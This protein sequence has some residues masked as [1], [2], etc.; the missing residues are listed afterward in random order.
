MSDIFSLVKESSIPVNVFADTYSRERYVES[1][2]DLLTRTN[3]VINE[4]VKMLY[5]KILEADSVE[6]ENIAMKDFIQE[7]QAELDKLSFGIKTSSQRFAIAL[8]NYCSSVKDQIDAIG[9]KDLSKCCYRGEYI[10][11]DKARMLNSDA[12]QM[13]PYK[14]FER[15]FNFIGQLMQ[16]LPV[17]A[18]NKDKLEI[19][20]T[21]YKNFKKSMDNNIVEKTYQDL[22]GLNSTDVK[23]TGSAQSIGRLVCG[24]FKSSAEDDHNI[25][26]DEYTDAVECISSCDEFIDCIDQ[27]STHLINDLKHIISDLNDILM[28]DSKN[29]FK[30]DTTEDGIRNTSYSID[31]YTSNKIMWLIQEKVKQITVVFNKYILALSVKMECILGYMRQSADIINSFTYM[32]CKAPKIDSEDKT[33]TEE[34][35]MSDDKDNTEES[36]SD[37]DLDD[38]INKDE[39]VSEEEEQESKEDNALDGGDDILTKEDETE[40]DVESTEDEDD[41]EIEEVSGDE[42]PEVDF[43]PEANEGDS[44]K[45]AVLDVITS[46]HEYNMICDQISLFEYAATLLMEEETNSDDKKEAL[47]GA[48]E[49]I[50]KAAEQKQSVWQS[51]MSK[52]LKM[53]ESFKEALA[54]T[55][56][57][58]I[59]KLKEAGIEKYVKEKPVDVEIKMPTIKLSALD[60]IKIED[61]NYDTMKEFLNSKDEFIKKYYNEFMP[62]KD[63]DTLSKTIEDAVIDRENLITKGSGLQI[64]EY[65][66]FVSKYPSYTNELKSMTKVLED[67]QRKAAAIAKDMTKYKPSNESFTLEDFYFNEGSNQGFE[68]D[69]KVNKD[70]EKKHEA[71]PKVQKERSDITKHMSTYF[72]VSG[73]ILHAKIV[74]S[75]KVF[76][77]FYAALMWHCGKMKDS[78]SKKSSGG[79]ESSSGSGESKPVSFD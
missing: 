30:V 60:S 74:T 57:L 56:V 65:W 45:E 54:K 59:E 33:N 16:D 77:E 31:K 70:N 6:S 53:W 41:S 51:I 27:T 76:N 22:F 24:M 55:Y 78:S 38:D 2:I 67:G 48:K 71:D 69:E 14:I 8:S 17:T 3:S 63:G 29:K 9:T 73:D 19:V 37:S 10:K 32:S 1:F 11:Y 36:D 13:N 44:L 20:S 43:E 4:Q 46:I 15:E 40:N 28:G 26:I 35:E 64:K 62:K 75:Q 5:S 34:D 39:E 66:D 68:G 7:I 79:G 52:I 21:V 18:S 12:P 50:G 61:L 72:G 25:C 23:C 58:K 47:A 49:A 42:E